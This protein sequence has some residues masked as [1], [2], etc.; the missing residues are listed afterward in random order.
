MD[1][2]R[3]GLGLVHEAQPGAELEDSD[4]FP[5][6]VPV[7]GFTFQARQGPGIAFRAEQLAQAFPIR[8]EPFEQFET[9]RH[10]LADAGH[11][12]ARQDGVLLPEGERV[13]GLAQPLGEMVEALFRCVACQE[14]LE[15]Q[16]IHLERRRAAHHTDH[17]GR[18]P[19]K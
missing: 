7:A 14:P 8:T 18:Q 16:H 6:P 13:L 2:Q 15:P 17:L 19:C 3:H 4:R 1:R 12:L 5:I 11:D 10:P 9:V